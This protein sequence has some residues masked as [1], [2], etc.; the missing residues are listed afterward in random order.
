VHNRALQASNLGADAILIS[1]PEYIK[2]PQ[3]D[4]FRHFN[5]V[6]KSFP[7]IPI[8]IYNIPCRTG[9]EILPK[10][11]ARLAQ[12]NANI[13]GIKQ[14]MGN[15][16]RISEM[17]ILCPPD[18]QI[19]SGDDSLTL[20]MMALGATGVI[21][22]T[23]HLEG[24]LI[25]DMIEKFKTGNPNEA[26]QIHQLLYPLI[27]TLFMTTNPIPVKEALYQRGIIK[28]PVL[29]TLSRMG[30]A[31][32]GKFVKELKRFNDQKK[33]YMLSHKNYSRERS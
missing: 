1:V 10:T 15:M 2:P 23:S 11:V 9:T 5:S 26:T 13:I 18:F 28:S 22:V 27:R 8:I 30:R 16:E 12:E 32:Q 6:A 14:S 31:D 21:S 25:Q 20:P 7:K 17:K 29:R 19:Y 4:L 24:R 3:R 33:A